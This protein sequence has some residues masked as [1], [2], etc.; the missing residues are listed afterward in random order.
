[1]FRTI[2]LILCENRVVLWSIFNWQ[3]LDTQLWGGRPQ[4]PL[5]RGCLTSGARLC[6]TQQLHLCHSPRRAESGQ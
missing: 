2:T 3:Q 6:V 4:Y 1:M 5:P